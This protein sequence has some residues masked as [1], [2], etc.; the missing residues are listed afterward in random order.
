MLIFIRLCA[1]LGAE[2]LAPQIG[3]ALLL[4]IFYFTDFALVQFIPKTAFSS[5]LLLSSIDM[6]SYWC[7]QSYFKTE[8]KLEWLVVPFIVI[9][10]FAFGLLQSVFLG[11]AISTFIFVASFCKF[12]IWTCGTATSG[13]FLSIPF[14]LLVRSG[15]VKFIANGM[16]VRSTIERPPHVSKWLE[17]SAMQIQILVL[18]NYLFFGN[19]SSMIAYISTMFE[20]PEANTNPNNVMPCPRVVII[21]M[22]LVTGMDTSAVD[23]FKDILT[24]CTNNDCKLFLSGVSPGLQKVMKLVG[25]HPGNLVNRSQRKLRFFVDLDTAIGKAEDVLI[26][27]S[28]FEE[29]ILL[30][31]DVQKRDG[32]YKALYH[33][34]VQHNTN[35]ATELCDFRQY[36]TTLD[37][38]PGDELYE[39]NNDQRGFFFIEHGILKME[40]FASDTIS[41]AGNSYS[42]RNTFRGSMSRFINSG[43]NHATPR[44]RLARSKF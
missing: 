8:Q 31:Y 19:A 36:A 27:I 44:F 2:R 14:T 23:A 13:I 37:L 43:N 39:E 9:L 16:H 20:E 11:I 32:F 1:K 30:P 22:T 15:V 7:I 35:F 12:R 28:S 21:D 29:E 24:V 38:V 18:Q 5:L 40:R 41:R 3:A 10:A 17:T 34:D 42:A 33:I 26:E 4:L 6:L 25:V